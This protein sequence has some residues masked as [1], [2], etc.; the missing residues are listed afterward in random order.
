MKRAFEKRFREIC[1][2]L[3]GNKIQAIVQIGT[4][5]ASEKELDQVLKKS[6]LLQRSWMT[7][8]MLILL[9]MKMKCMKF[10]IRCGTGD[11]PY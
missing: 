10:L 3:S 7:Q 2:Q 11:L 6:D 4:V 8:K 5:E 1:G 9:S